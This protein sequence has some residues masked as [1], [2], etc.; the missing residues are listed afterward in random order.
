[1]NMRMN[2]HVLPGRHGRHQAGSQLW[3]CWPGSGLQ[4]PALDVAVLLHARAR[5]FEIIATKRNHIS[6]TRCI[7]EYEITS[8][9]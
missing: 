8:A 3:S 5:G 9:R 1:M 6:D 4:L 7:A 2:A